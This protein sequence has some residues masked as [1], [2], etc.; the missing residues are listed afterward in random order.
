MSK[1]NKKNVNSDLEID[2]Q[3]TSADTQQEE[4]EESSTSK[5]RRENRESFWKFRVL[6]LLFIW[7]IFTVYLRH[8]NAIS[9]P[10]VL[11]GGFDLALLL[12]TLYMSGIVKSRWTAI[13]G[14][15]LALIP[16]FFVR[17][18]YELYFP[19]STKFGTY[20]GDLWYC[21]SYYLDRGFAY[22]REYPSGIQMIFRFIFKFK[23]PGLKYEGYIIGISIFL[24]IF[25]LLVTY[26]LHHIVSETHKKTEKIWIFWIL[27]PTFLWYALLNMDLMSIF[28]V[29]M[30]YFLFI[31]DEYYMSSAMLA[32]GAAAKVFPFFLAPLFFFQCPKKEYSPEKL[33]NLSNTFKTGLKFIPSFI[34]DSILGFLSSKK[35]VS[36]F[37]VTWRFR[38]LSVL[39]FVL[40]WFAFNIPFMVKEWEAWKYPYEWQIKHNYAKSTKDGSYFWVIHNVLNYAEDKMDRKLSRDGTA[41][42]IHKKLTPYKHHMGKISLIMFALLYFIFL[43]FRWN[44][45]FA[46]RCAG[47]ILLFLLTDRIY[48]PQYNLYLLPFLVLVDYKFKKPMQNFLFMSAFYLVG[49]LSCSQTIF[50]F[51]IREIFMYTINVKPFNPL[52]LPLLF[53][54]VVFLKYLL[55]IYLFFVNWTAPVNPDSENWK[56]GSG[57]IIDERYKNGDKIPLIPS[58]ENASK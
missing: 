32:L 15:A 35:G 36:H 44:L 37:L 43:K 23:P 8:N 7:I 10:W 53:Q 41:W 45:P 33:D 38:L 34:S 29:V 54:G 47:V 51:K 16:Q 20:P 5:K 17:S 14:T 24:G 21:W 9:I 3:N 56:D 13:F 40:V 6:P 28:T 22:P 27:A 12:T 39:V 2:E 25:A 11:L 4:S 18:S 42:K 52:E 48:S 55:L 31:E 1:K 30:A 49:I 58:V 19:L 46:R 57:K 26:I 50:L